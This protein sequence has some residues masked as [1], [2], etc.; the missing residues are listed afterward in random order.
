VKQS[1][2]KDCKRTI[3]QGSND[4]MSKCQTQVPSPRDAAISYPS[5]EEDKRTL[6][7]STLEDGDEEISDAKDSRRPNSDVDNTPVP[8]MIRD[9]E[10]EHA[11]GDFQG[12]HGDNV[13][14]LHYDEP[15]Q[16]SS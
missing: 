6:K 8:F 15:L 16:I 4:A 1:E 2:G 10:K 5:D 9:S 12:N 7:I 11:D 14:D 13:K 3:C